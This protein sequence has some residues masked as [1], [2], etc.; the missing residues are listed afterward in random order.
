MTNKTQ[1]YLAAVVNSIKMSQV[2]ESELERR[3]EQL[4]KMEKEALKERRRFARESIPSF[5]QNKHS[6]FN[7]QHKHQ[8]SILK[9]SKRR[10]IC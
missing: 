3:A 9:Q 2:F 5:L 6:K 10:R 4:R 1:M 7:Q 8:L